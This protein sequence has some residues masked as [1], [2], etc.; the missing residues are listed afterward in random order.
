M[1]NAMLSLA[2]A[3]GMDEMDD[4]GDSTAELSLSMPANTLTSAGS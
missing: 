2:H 3:L 1:A 4:F